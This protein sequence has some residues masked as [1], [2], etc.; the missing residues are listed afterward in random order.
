[1]RQAEAKLPLAHAVAL[2][3]LHGPAELLPISSSAHTTLIPWLAG[4]PYAQLEDELRKAFEVAL[5][6]GAGAALAIA[7][8]AE[9]RRSLARMDG[10]RAS[11]LALALAPPALT[12]YLLEGTIERR[13]GSPRSIAA[14]LAA[15]ALAMAL[16][17]AGGGS[18]DTQRQSE[19]AGTRDGLALGLGQASALIPGVS[20]NGATL[21]AA[22][23]RSFTRAAAQ[24]LSWEVGLPV[25]LGASLLK[26]LR[27]RRAGIRRE[28]GAALAAGAAAAFV[29]TLAS[30]RALRRGTRDG[31]SLWP[32]ALYRCLLAALVIARGRAQ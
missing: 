19:D 13:L 5:H 29:S 26:G 31:R 11:V 3:L 32:Y 22:R 1:M 20:R 10:R 27:L 15:G 16:A 24:T 9:L 4:W 17:D 23:A 21:S 14:G 8:R 6:A 25:I 12:G 18:A 28:H 2:G 7:M 30:A